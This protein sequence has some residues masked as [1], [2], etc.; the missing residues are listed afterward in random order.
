[1]WR[2]ITLLLSLA[3]FSLAS[4]LIQPVSGEEYPTRP[5]ELLCSYS[6]GSS[7]DI[8]ARIVAEV[9]PKYLRQPMVV[10]SKLGA[11]GSIAAADVV[12]SKPDGYKLTQ[13]S[14][15]YFATTTKT[16]KLLFDPTLLTPIANIYQLK[17]GLLVKGDSPWKSLADLLDFAKK[18]PG[19]LRWTHTGRGVPPHL[20]GMSIFRKAGVITIDVPYKGTPEAIAAILGGHADAYSGP[21]GA[22]KEQHRAGLVKYL[23]FYATKRYSEPSE[24]PCALELGFSDAAKLRVLFGVYAHKNTPE[25]VKKTLIDAFKKIYEDP[26][27]KKEMEK[28]GD[29]L[30]YGDPEFLMKAI[31]ESEEAGVPILKELGLYKEQK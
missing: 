9:A 13:Q 30:I 28:L 23:V 4:T 29:E 2:K 1:M 11:G 3:T 18:N 16:Q 22:V 17:V 7:V 19:K 27:F 15:A 10:V 14:Q 24:V 31:E 20:A 12:S 26:Q 8:A 25:K 5:I 21:Y 6:P